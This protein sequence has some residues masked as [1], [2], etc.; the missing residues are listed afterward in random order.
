MRTT[1]MNCWPRACGRSSASRR[2]GFSPTLGDVGL[3][4]QGVGRGC[5]GLTPRQH[6]HKP[7]LLRRQRIAA[8][9]DAIPAGLHEVPDVLVIRS[10]RVLQYIVPIVCAE[11]MQCLLL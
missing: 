3:H 9:L 2:S 4:P 10:I 1:G 11:A 6:T 7:D 5:M 8:E